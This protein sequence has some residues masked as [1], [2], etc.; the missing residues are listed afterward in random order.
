MGERGSR[1][2]LRSR[3]LRLAGIRLVFAHET[4]LTLVE[5]GVCT[6][7]SEPQPPGVPQADV[8]TVRLVSTGFK[9]CTPL[10]HLSSQ[11]QV[12]WDLA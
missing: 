7:R 9:T 5:R 8:S 4:P 6:Q 12:I 2:T 3:S 1:S 11:S 10:C